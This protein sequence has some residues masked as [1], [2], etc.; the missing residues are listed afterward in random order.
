VVHV[1]E[2]KMSLTDPSLVQMFFDG[3]TPRTVAKSMIAHAQHIKES[4]ANRAAGADA[5][6]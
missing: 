6:S 3:I 1:G 2:A 5:E 4:G